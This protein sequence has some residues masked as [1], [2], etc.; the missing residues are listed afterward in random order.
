MADF[1]SKSEID[2]LLGALNTGTVEKSIDLWKGRHDLTILLHPNVFSSNDFI[3][4]GWAFLFFWKMGF[5]RVIY[6]IDL[7][8]SFV[9]KL[10]GIKE[11]S[12]YLVETLLYYLNKR[13]EDIRRHFSVLEY[14]EYQ[15]RFKFNFDDLRKEIKG[16]ILIVVS[17]EDSKNFEENEIRIV[18]FG[19]FM[20]KIFSENPNFQR[21]IEL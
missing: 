3:D 19:G 8:C 16:N 13:P 1:L 20:L 14:G 12:K 17:D 6:T 10:E 2:A 11:K 4:F 21:K 5:F 7:Q 9:E 18:P 15:N